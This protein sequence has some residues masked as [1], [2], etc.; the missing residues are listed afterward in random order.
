MASALELLK[1]HRAFG[2]QVRYQRHRS[3]VCNGPMEFSVFI[4]PLAERERAPVVYYLSGLTCTPENFTVQAGAQRIA[5]ELG[6]ILVAP[7]TSPRA[8][9]VPG[10]ADDWDY[11][12]GAG[13][14]VDAT[15]EPWRESYQMYSYIT[16][17]LPQLIDDTYPTQGKD[18]RSIFGHAM[19]GHGALVAALRSPRAW[20]SVSAFSPV[21]APSQVP[22]GQKAFTGYLG[23]DRAS[24]ARYDATELVT[25]KTHPTTILVDQGT[26]DQFLERE[27]KPEL[28]EAAC[29]TAG[30]ALELRRHAGYDHSYF[31]IASFMEDHLQHHAAHL[32][33]SA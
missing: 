32:R 17:E 20:R 3:E 13:F 15:E 10:E 30:Q 6:L 12:T 2:G 22:W 19:G 31:F 11:G 5:A 14:Y 24:W 23:E 33:N 8:A 4:P 9:E 18:Q 1:H 26:R 27:L 21:V 16:E 28:F 7:D 25:T 29:E